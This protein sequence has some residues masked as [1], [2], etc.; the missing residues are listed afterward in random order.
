MERERRRIVRAAHVAPRRVFGR[1]AGR[2]ARRPFGRGGEE[3]SPIDDEQ[4]FGYLIGAAEF[5]GGRATCRAKRAR[6]A[7]QANLPA[8]VPIFSEIIMK[9][10]PAAHSPPHSERSRTRI[11]W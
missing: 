1:A 3:E 11:K 2:L 8:A 4:E 7:G 6:R 5:S 10:M 9:R